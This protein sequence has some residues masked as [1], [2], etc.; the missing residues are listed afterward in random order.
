MEIFEGITEH[1]LEP[2]SFTY[3]LLIKGLKN[4]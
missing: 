1:G 2:D 4:S 3:S